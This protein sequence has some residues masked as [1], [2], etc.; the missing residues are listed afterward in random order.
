MLSRLVFAAFFALAV[1]ASADPPGLFVAV[2]YGG[3]RLSSH[4]GV[5][6]ENDQRWSD[7]AKDDDN[8]LFNLA[9]GLGRFVAVGG[10]AMVGHLLTT[11]DGKEWRELPRQKGRVA[12]VA[13]GRERFVA[14]H[15]AELLW[16]TD[17]ETFTAGEKLPVQ[18]SVHARRS[19]CGDTE[20][21]FRFVLIGDV[22]L[23][24]EGRRVSWRGATG[25]GTRWEHHAVGSPPA[26]DVAHGAGLFICVGPAGL[27]ESSHDGQSWTRRESDAAE[28][29]QRV[30]WTGSRFLAKGKALWS[31]PDG[32]VWTREKSSP[33]CAPAWAR[34]GIGA[35]GFAWGGHLFRAGPDL[36][37]WKKVALPPGLS[38]E[39]VAWGTP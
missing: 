16:S 38:L 5:L 32:V 30:V 23:A 4:D 29:F 14:G 25:D 20:A 18:G 13:F 28:D 26:S 27:I 35:F 7:E 37:E 3:R 17:G 21:G 22:D 12:T 24:G 15:D 33:P 11:R 6:W 39:A 10:G 34:D 31:S 1:R 36:M 8:V 19:A 2:G 9:F